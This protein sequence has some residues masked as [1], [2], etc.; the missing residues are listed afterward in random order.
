[1]NFIFLSALTFITNLIKSYCFHFSNINFLFSFSTLNL[2]P[3]L[4]KTYCPYLFFRIF[5]RCIMLCNWSIGC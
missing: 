3:N 2:I 5:M 4:I 1:M